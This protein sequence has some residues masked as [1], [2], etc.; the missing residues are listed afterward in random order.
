VSFL[1]GVSDQSFLAD[2]FWLTAITSKSIQQTIKTPQA[3]K[4]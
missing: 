2:L 3:T 1:A 4:T